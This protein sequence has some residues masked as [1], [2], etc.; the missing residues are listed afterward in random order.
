M[1]DNLK[2]LRPHWKELSRRCAFPEQ[3]SQAVFQL[4]LQAYAE[5]QRHYHT[6]QHIAECLAL[7]SQIQHLLDDAPS[8]ALALWFHDAVYDPQAPDNEERSAALMMQS[9]TGLLSE[10]QLCK[11][12]AWIAATK[13]HACTDEP[14]LQYLLDIDLAVLAAGAARFAEYEAQIRKEYA[15]VDAAQYQ[16]RRRE[17]LSGFYQA[18]PLYQTGY[19]QQRFERQAKRNLA[20]QLVQEK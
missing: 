19:F 14:D 17:V 15:W 3:R 16:R 1:Q 7:Y 6:A 10:A 2:L 8:L 9:C 4:L 18:Q 11:A 5:P 13:L 20:A 12:A